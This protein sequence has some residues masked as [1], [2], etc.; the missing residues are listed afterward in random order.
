MAY[1][2][3]TW[4]DQIVTDPTK[5]KITKENGTEELV[6]IQKAPGEI[7]QEGTRITAE[8]LNN[9]EQGIKGAAD[10]VGDLAGEGRTEETVKKNAEDIGRVSAQMADLATNKDTAQD[11]QVL[12]S[13]GDGTATFKNEYTHPTGAGYKHIPSGGNIGEVL[14]NS[15]NG[16]VEWG[17]PSDASLERFYLYKQGIEYVPFSIH[18]EG[19]ATVQKQSKQVLLDLNIMNAK[20]NATFYTSQPINLQGFN[21]IHVIYTFERTIGEYAP[22]T[23]MII[24]PIPYFDSSFGPGGSS[25]ELSVSSSGKQYLSRTLDISNVDNLQY[26]EVKL[27]YYN[28]TRGC[29][30]E[31]QELYLTKN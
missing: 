19:G 3:T 24:N 30:V 11:G 7:V 13:N 29:K 25:V 14:I 17:Q 16:Q 10:L 20:K 22:S 4:K 27:F 6:N 31:L 15:G 8:K 18:T 5:Y 26:V 21:A 1:N 12:K 28:N 9:M 23:N 2:P